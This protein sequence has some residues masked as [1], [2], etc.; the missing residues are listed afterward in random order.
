M[1][2]MQHR[3]SH[4]DDVNCVLRTGDGGGYAKALNPPGQEVVGAVDSGLA[5]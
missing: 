3:A 1:E 2:R 5:S 4:I